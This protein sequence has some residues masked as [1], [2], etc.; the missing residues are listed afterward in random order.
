M[1]F[2]ESFFV[3]S[4]YLNAV[5]NTIAIRPNEITAPFKGKLSLAASKDRALRVSG[6]KGKK[7]Y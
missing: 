2:G 4:P 5:T 1:F 3:I 7:A 6:H